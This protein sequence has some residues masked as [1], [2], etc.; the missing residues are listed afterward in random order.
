MMLKASQIACDSPH[1][2]EGYCERCERNI[3]QRLA[4][5]FDWSNKYEPFEKDSR[6]KIKNKKYTCDGFIKKG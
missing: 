6:L 4:Q 3:P 2:K 5:Y 1:K